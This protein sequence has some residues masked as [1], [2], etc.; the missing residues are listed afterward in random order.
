MNSCSRFCLNQETTFKL[1]SES[2]GHIFRRSW[3]VRESTSEQTGLWEEGRVESW[4]RFSSLG[5]IA[6]IYSLASC[7]EGKRLEGVLGMGTSRRYGG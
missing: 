2:P 7:E 1:C 5:L 4:P 6:L 3:L